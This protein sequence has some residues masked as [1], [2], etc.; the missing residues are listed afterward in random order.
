MTRRDLQLDA[1]DKGRPWEFGKSFA[2]SAPIGV[3]HRAE[4]IGHPGDAAITLTVNGEPRQSSDISKLLWS[5]A[6]S[7]A[8]LSQYETLEPGDLINDRY[9]G[10]RELRRARGRAA[11]RDPGLGRDHGHRRFLIKNIEETTMDT[12]STV[13][14]QKIHWESDGTSRIPFMAYTEADQHRKE[15][16]RLF[17][18]KHWCYVGLEAEIPE[19]GDFK[20]SSAALGA[21]RT[22][23]RHQH[24][25]VYWPT[26]GTVSARAPRQIAGEQGF[27]AQHL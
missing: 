13:F 6:E 20:L 12:A 24:V 23:R 27:C 5:V 10:G 7:I 11:R 1:R 25:R 22:R 2:T 18:R 26:G 8:V 19:P 16:E 17:Y 21:L 15:L 14:P 9:P 3:I 4:D